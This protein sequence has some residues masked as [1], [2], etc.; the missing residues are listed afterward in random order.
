MPEKNFAGAV[1]E[2]KEKILLLRQE[3]AEVRELLH[4]VDP[5]RKELAITGMG[6]TVSLG[7][8]TVALYEAV[9]GLAEA[10]DYIHNAVKALSF[11]NPTGKEVGD[12]EH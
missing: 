9:I 11:T 10:V 2:H 3:L 8:T 7:E 6:L 5:R 1:A 4:K 12:T